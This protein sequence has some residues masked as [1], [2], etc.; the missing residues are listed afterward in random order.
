M[1]DLVSKI[2]KKDRPLF[3]FKKEE[4]KTLIEL[5]KTL[6]IIFYVTKMFEG[7]GMC[8]TVA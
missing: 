1:A 5:E 7:N 4:K 8:N 6:G 3:T 2:D